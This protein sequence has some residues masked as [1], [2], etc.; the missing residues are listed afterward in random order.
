MGL[1]LS[2]LRHCLGSETMKPR[3]DTW[4]RE[5]YDYVCDMLT[6]VMIAFCL[7]NK[8]CIQGDISKLAR[9]MMTK[10]RDELDQ[11]GNVYHADK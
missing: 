8:R 10:C 9:R 7:I 11:L 1:R 4:D 5:H 2:L 6:S 3:P